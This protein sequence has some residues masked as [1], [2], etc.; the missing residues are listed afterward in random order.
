MS[1]EESPA[2]F[3]DQAIKGSLFTLFL[4]CPLTALCLV[5]NIIEL[6]IQLWERA[7]QV[8]DR[9]LAE[10]G[11]LLVR[12]RATDA[13]YIQFYADDFLRLLTLRYVFCAVV[14]RMHRLF[15]VKLSGGGVN[16]MIGF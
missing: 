15:R 6:S 4:H 9:F 7:Q 3:H 14:L 5:S 12:S 11:R 16:L 1:P 10:A 13:A 8:V 2:P